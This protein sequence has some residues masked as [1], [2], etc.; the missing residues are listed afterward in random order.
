MQSAEPLRRLTP[1]V[2]RRT[3]LEITLTMSNIMS[4]NQATTKLFNSSQSDVLKPADTNPVAVPAQ[5]GKA[6]RKHPVLAGAATVF[7]ATA[8]IAYWAGELPVPSLIIAAGAG[9]L[10]YMTYLA[11]AFR[12]LIKDEVVEATQRPQQAVDNWLG[13]GIGRIRP[14][15][16]DT[17]MHLEVGTLCPAHVG[18]ADKEHA[19]LKR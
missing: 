12:N 4:M 9:Y 3:T 14:G 7:V 6:A 2:G 15:S 18:A 10:A 8:G 19:V 13:A 1:I 11:V 16:D 17:S 5:S